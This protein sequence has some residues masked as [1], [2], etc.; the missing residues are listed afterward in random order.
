MRSLSVTEAR[1]RAACISVSSYDIHLDLTRG[2]DQFR[3]HTTVGFRS[4]DG[5]ATFVDVSASQL[6][7]V[8]L[9]GEPLK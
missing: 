8:T 9:N 7:S 6:E 1:T 2:P 5:A 3:S 4:I